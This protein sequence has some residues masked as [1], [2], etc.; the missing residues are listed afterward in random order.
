[1]YAALARAAL[2]ETERDKVVTRIQ[3]L[4]RR[5]PRASKEE[6]ANRL[7]HSTARQCAAAGLAW[8]SPAAFFGSM[9]TGPD[10]AFQILALNRLVL[11]LAALYRSE[12]S[13]RDRVMGVAS[14]LGA[15]LA[16]DQ[17]RRLIVAGLSRAFPR[18]PGARA[19]AGG[20]L[21][22]ALFYGMAT[23]VGQVALEL[24]ADRGGFRR[25]RLLR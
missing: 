25:R 5:H 17:L 22:G 14:G 8:S 2:A 13:G 19:V 18:R 12:A 10:L 21:C 24:L 20:L 6:L 3:Q 23:A 4:R 7:I 15:G 11:G 1:M 9:P 16:A